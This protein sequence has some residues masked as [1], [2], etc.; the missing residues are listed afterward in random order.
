MKTLPVLLED[1][2]ERPRQSLQDP[3]LVVLYQEL[4]EEDLALAEA[5][6][7]DYQRGLQEADRYEGLKTPR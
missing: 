5:G 6:M 7:G 1:A 3:A 4:A 2:S